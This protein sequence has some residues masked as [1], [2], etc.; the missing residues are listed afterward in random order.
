MFTF[1]GVLVLGKEL[2]RDPER[3]HRELR[4]RAAAAA[5]AVRAGA[6]FVATLEAKLGGQA[7]SGA[8]LVHGLLRELGVPEA[9]IVARPL[10]RSTREEAWLGAA[11]FAEREVR[12]GLVITARYHVA[13]ARRLFAEALA[14]AE[15]HAPMAL[16]RWATPAERAWITAGEPD[17][18]A[19]RAEA[20]TERTFGWLEAALRPLP[21]GLATMVEVR[22]GAWLRGGASL[23]SG[24]DRAPGRVRRRPLPDAAPAFHD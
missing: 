9:K 20:A 4:A 6:P 13:R 17:A 16:W 23:A 24:S 21:T 10:T 12:R 7:D 1:D 11:L 22:A 14:P 18:A 2:R 15:V 5:A 8:E 3:A 19:M